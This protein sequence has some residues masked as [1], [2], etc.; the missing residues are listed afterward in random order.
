[1]TALDTIREKLAVEEPWVE[2]RGTL[3]L[4]PGGANVRDVA[5]AM[6]AAGARF[7]TITAYELPGSEGFR[8]EYHWDLEGRL[9]GVPF[10]IAGKTTESIVDITEA[11]DWIEREVHEGFAIT[12]TGRAYEPLLLREGDEPG[13]NL[14]QAPTQGPTQGGPTGG[15]QPQKEVAQ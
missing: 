14:R 13:V 8:L 11:A 3:W 12:F 4:N 5:W 2:S 1:M 9:L 6:Q 10:Q 7:I 15:T